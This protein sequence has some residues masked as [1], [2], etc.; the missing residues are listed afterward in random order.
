MTEGLANAANKVLEFLGN[1]ENL[2]GT[3]IAVSVV[4]GGIVAYSVKQKM[5]AAQTATLERGKLQTK[6][7][8]LTLDK[9]G[10]TVDTTRKIR[11]T[12]QLA[13]D[14]AD[15]SA[16]LVSWLGPI[17]L[18]LIP[19][20]L[21]T[22]ASISAGGSGGGGGASINASDM[23]GINPVNTNAQIPLASSTTAAG[24][25]PAVNLQVINKM[26]PLNGK[27]QTT[28]YDRDHGGKIDNQSGVIGNQ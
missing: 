27:H 7:T 13:L 19:V 10:N 25:K 18:G 12:E 26:D 20:L 2:K 5:L 4:I 8:E 23:G 24:N 21:A 17:G 15:A 14:E 16:K 9:D 1:I 11:T 3:L 28:I 22:L 6:I